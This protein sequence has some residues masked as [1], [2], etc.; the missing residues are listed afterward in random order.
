MVEL[1]VDNTA[2]PG[3]VNY[4]LSYTNFSFGANYR[5]TNELSGFARYSKGNRA[6]SD[7]L[8]YSANINAVTGAL[9]STDHQD[10]AVADLHHIVED[11]VASTSSVCDHIILGEAAERE[12]ERGQ[13]KEVPHGR[14]WLA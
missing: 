3:L 14:I 13:E 11:L 1:A 9:T 5:L 8:L 6:I 10:A 12:Q 4:K 2:N 7:R